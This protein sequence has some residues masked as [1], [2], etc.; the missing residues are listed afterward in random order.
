MR[1]PPPTWAVLDAQAL[2]W[3]EFYGAARRDPAA[4]IAGLSARARELCVLHGAGGR[5]AWCLDAG[6]YL[7]AALHP[8]YKSTRAAREALEPPD[9]RAAK[10]DLR[11][12]AGEFAARLKSAG[13]RSVFRAPGYE[14]DDWCAAAVRAVPCGHR[15]VVCSRDRDLFQLLSESACL[16]DPHERR[17]CGRSW[18]RN[19]HLDLHPAQW[20]EV[21]AVAGCATDDVP[22]CDGAGETYAVRY[23]SGNLPETYQA[24]RKIREWVASPGYALALKLV[25]LPFRGTPVVA[26]RETPDPERAFR[27]LDRAL[28]GV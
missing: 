1:P 15:A 9:L 6:P 3:Q 23:L 18:F 24:N 5:V 4:A 27:A 11:A 25:R 20:A 17:A 21:K 8:A 14:A 12:R 10:A 22:G 7:R 19:E 13:F 16:Y 28:W 26:L 2:L